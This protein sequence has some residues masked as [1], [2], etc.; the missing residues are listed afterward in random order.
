MR[1]TKKIAFIDK[2]KLDNHEVLDNGGLMELEEK[3]NTLVPLKFFSGIFFSTWGARVAVP[4]LQQ[5]FQAD[6]CRMSFGRYTLFSS[7]ST[8][9]NCNTSPFAFGILFGNE[10]KDDWIQFWKFAKS[11]HQSINE[12]DVTIITVQAKGLTELIAEVLPLMAHF[13]CFFQRR[14]NTTKIVRGGTQKYSCL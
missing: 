7:Y 14:Q 4:F 11:V 2:W 13:H 6:V 5:V 3:D 9:A 1:K 12:T 10:D 8:T